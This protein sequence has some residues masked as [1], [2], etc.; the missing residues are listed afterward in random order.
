MS[1]EMTI[2]FNTHGNDKQKNVCR[3]WIDKETSEIVYGGSKGSGKSFLGVSLIFGDAFLHPN[4]QYFIARNSLTNLR[5]FTIP[6]IHE[7]FAIWGIKADM[8]KFNGQDSFFLLNNGSKVF[9]LDCSYQPSDPQYYRFG[10]IQMTR[11]FIEETGEVDHG[12]KNNLAASI[13]RWKN[14]EYNLTPKL[15]MT[16]NPSKNF[17]YRDYY[18]PN[19]AGTLESWRKFVQAF[20]EDNKMLDDGYLEN[21]KRSLTQNEQQR[22]LYGNWE[23]DDD[24]S[25]LIDYNKI[26]DTF[27][28]THIPE[29]RKCIT[30]DMARLGGDKIVIVEWS[31][32]RGH[33]RFYQKQDL[34]TTASMLEAARSR[35]GCGKSDILI[36]E[37]GLGGGVV[38]FYG[39]KGF[40]N[41]ARPL[42][43][44]T[45]PQKDQKGNIKPE[46]FDHQKSQCYY[47]LAERINANGMHIT[48]DD[49]R[50]REWLIQELEQVKQKRLDSDMKKGVMAKDQVKE[51][52]GRSPDFAD[53]LMMR[54][55][56]ELMPKF[57]LTPQDD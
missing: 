10:S 46:N 14:N 48:Y 49:D 13:G 8:W 57:V 21:L 28:N 11:G 15:L 55:A 51:L 56:F 20:P 9:L 45:N 54:E 36:D 41:N 17:L 33:V 32:F 2:T 31:G 50:V 18:I 37:D 22:L 27:S 4:T 6:S 43:S 39:C 47:K 12:A 53:A 25:A 38:D 35:L 23:F 5:K 26:I 7:V 29:G 44:P 24:P 1:N 19:K 3:L 16:C 40:V 52:I 30:G 34:A 42:P